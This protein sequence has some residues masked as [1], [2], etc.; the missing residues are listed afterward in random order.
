MHN[1]S[2]WRR[3]HCR[4]GRF[5]LLCNIWHPFDFYIICIPIPAIRGTV[6]SVGLF[7]RAQLSP[8]RRAIAKCSPDTSSPDHSQKLT[9]RLRTLNCYCT[10]KLQRCRCPRRQD[11]S[12][13]PDGRA[14]AQLRFVLDIPYDKCRR[15]SNCIN[16]N[17]KFAWGEYSHLRSGKTTM[18]ANATSVSIENVPNDCLISIYLEI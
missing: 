6:W 7:H 10:S 8:S 4:E 11:A 2:F 3:I 1:S 15:P 13:T 14:A 12:I 18:L 16:V 5:P 17:L 9:E